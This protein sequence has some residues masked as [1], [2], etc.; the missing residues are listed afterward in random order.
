MVCIFTVPRIS[1]IVS[2]F[3]NPASYFFCLFF[4]NKDKYADFAFTLQL[5]YAV[6]LC[7]MTWLKMIDKQ[8]RY[9][10][11]KLLSFSS[12]LFQVTISSYRIS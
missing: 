12:C 2:T 7:L 9:L 6:P 10:A 1:E 4:E 5:S 8:Q 3:S 11:V